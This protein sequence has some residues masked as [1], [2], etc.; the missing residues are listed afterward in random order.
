MKLAKK[1]KKQKQKKPYLYLRVN[2]CMKGSL[3][4]ASILRLTSY[5]V[6]KLLL[7]PLFI[8]LISLNDIDG[9]TTKLKIK[10]S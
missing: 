9:S 4:K 1:E 3:P 7:I 8:K 5:L 2:S 6:L 10:L